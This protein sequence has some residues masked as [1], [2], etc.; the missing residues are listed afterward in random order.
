M[1]ASPEILAAAVRE[2]RIAIDQDLDRLRAKLKES[3]PRTRLDPKRLAWRA[4]PALAG[5]AVLWM[6][7]RRRRRIVSLRGLLV[8]RLRQLYAAEGEQLQ[9]LDRMRR[10]AWNEELASA[11]HQHRIETEGHIGRLERVFRSVGARPKPAP[12]RA[13]SAIVADAERLLARRIQRDVRDA[14][15]IGTAQRIE[16]LEIANYGTAR[17]YAQTLGFTDAAQLLQETL[18]EEQIADKR[19]TRIAEQFVNPQSIR[20]ARAD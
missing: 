11:L 7:T 2:K 6:L 5:G 17:T 18:E 1:D 10:E 12:L 13:V 15:L 8:Y 20:R 19:L 9:M 14:S 16:H 3:D 4:L